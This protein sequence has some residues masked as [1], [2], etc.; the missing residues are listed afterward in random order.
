MP[1]IVV[2]SKTTTIKQMNGVFFDFPVP[3]VNEGN[4]KFA[5]QQ[6]LQPSSVFLYFAEVV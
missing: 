1:V 4:M 3:L 5:V 2:L 6:Y